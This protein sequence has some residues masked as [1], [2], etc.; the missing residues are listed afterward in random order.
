MQVR[1]RAAVGFPEDLLRLRGHRRRI[2]RPGPPT[3]TTDTGKDTWPRSPD[4][5][6]SEILIRIT[7]ATA[8][9]FSAT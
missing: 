4:S 8:E 3:T 7:C 5:V 9:G 6:G 1:C 2:T